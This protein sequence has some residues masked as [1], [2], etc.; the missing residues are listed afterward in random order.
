MSETRPTPAQTRMAIA[1]LMADGRER[2]ADDIRNR[3]PAD[4]ATFRAAM[5]FMVKKR[6]LTA[7]EVKSRRDTFRAYRKREEAKV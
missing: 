3:V 7:R 1:R 2:T 6:L 4:P 5:L